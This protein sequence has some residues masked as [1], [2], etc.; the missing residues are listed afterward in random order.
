MCDKR[1][2]LRLVLISLVLLLLSA[3]G[4]KDEAETWLE[5][6]QDKLER[7]AARVARD[8]DDFFDTSGS[9]G[10]GAAPLALSGAT[11]ALLRAKKRSTTT[12]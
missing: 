9:G 10:C 7:Q 1:P 3:C 5:D 8:I 12:G 6:Q 2:L 11:L 4:A